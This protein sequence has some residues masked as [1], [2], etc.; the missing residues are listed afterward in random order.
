MNIK[1][2]QVLVVGGGLAGLV[3]AKVAKKQ[4]KEVVIAAKSGGIS[5]ICCGAFDVLGAIPGANAK[6]VVNINDGVKQLTEIKSDH[7]YAKSQSLD[8]AMET[9]VELAS[10]GGYKVSGDGRKNV[11]LPNIYG[12]FTTAAYVPSFLKAGALD[13]GEQ[14]ERNVLVVGFNGHQ[15]FNCA[16]A[17]QSYAYVGRRNNISN[18]KYYSANI[19]LPSFKNRT[20]VSSAEIA[21]FVDT[22]EGLNEFVQTVKANVSPKLKIDLILC[23]PALGF[24]KTDEIITKLEAETGARVAEVA[25]AGSS[26]VGFRLSRALRRGVESSDIPFLY[27]CEAEN[28][29]NV[30]DKVE[31]SFVSGVRDYIHP[32]QKHSILADKVILATGGFLGGGLSRGH[33]TVKVNLVNLDLGPITEDEVNYDVFDSKGQP[34]LNK[35]LAVDENMQ[36]QNVEFKNIFA[37]GDIVSGFDGIYEKSSAG[38]AAITAYDAALA[39][40]K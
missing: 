16:H 2:T 40:S 27:G 30:D 22:E 29:K 36:P 34:Y 18:D 9:L 32:G 33:R 39:A 17:A 10:E 13:V 23:S 26:V 3:A 8:R 37:C 35:G 28:I 1:E 21:E 12:T 6:I 25:C 5:E 15:E 20:R 31:V 38:V 4:G 7:P 24:Y 14:K 19:T 11:F